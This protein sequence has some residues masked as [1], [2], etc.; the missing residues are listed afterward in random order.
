VINNLVSNAIKFTEK[1]GVTIRLDAAVGSDSR[2][3]LSIAVNDTGIGITRDQLDR[4]FKPFQQAD[5]STTRRFGGSGLGL[6][7]TRKLCELM[8]GRLEVNS[9]P[10]VGSTFIAHVQLPL[11]ETAQ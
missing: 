1:G 2:C 3:N 5:S 11:A 4:L 9:E 6:F 7:I 8:S 10:G